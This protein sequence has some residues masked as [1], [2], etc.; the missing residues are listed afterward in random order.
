MKKAFCTLMALLLC[1]ILGGAAEETPA[2]YDSWD[3]EY[4]W[5]KDGSVAIAKYSGEADDLSIPAQVDGRPVTAIGEYAFLGCTSLTSVTIPD[6]VSTI[7]LA[8][9]GNCSNLTSVLI[10]SHDLDIGELAFKNC[11]SL[12]SIILPEGTKTIGKGAFSFCSSLTSVIIPD[13]VTTIGNSAFALCSKLNSISIPAS[14]SSVGDGIFVGCDG[15]TSLEI[16]DGIQVIPALMFNKCNGLI[17]ISIP[18]SVTSI[19]KSAF[20]ECANLTTVT[21]PD[22][23]TTIGDAVFYNCQSLTSITIPASVTSIGLNTFLS[24]DNL[25]LSVFKGSYA[26]QYCRDNGLPFEYSESVNQSNASQLEAEKEHTPSPTT[27][28][29]ESS[30]QDESFLMESVTQDPDHFKYCDYRRGAFAITEYN[31]SAT[32]LAIPASINGIPVVSIAS[33]AKYNETVTALYIPESVENIDGNPFVS[34][35]NLNSFYVAGENTNFEA[36]DGILYSKGQKEL[37]CYPSGRLDESF[38]IP[39]GTLRIGKDA[40]SYNHKISQLILPEGLLRIG[41]KAFF[42]MSSVHS[43]TIPSTVTE[44]GSNPFLQMLQLE[45][46]TVAPGN[47][48]FIIQ[49]GALYNKNTKLIICYPSQYASTSF[50]FPEDTITIGIGAFMR[51]TNL[52]DIVL[53]STVISIEV[54]AFYL[55]DNMTI[56]NLPSSIQHIGDLAFSGVCFNQ[57]TIPN[58]IQSVE[59]QCFKAAKCQNAIFESGIIV[60]PR[61]IFQDCTDLRTVQLPDTVESIESMS[62]SHCTSLEEIKL[63]ES[64]SFIDNTAF[65][66]CEALVACVVPGSYSEEYCKEQGIAYRY[67]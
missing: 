28:P 57:L 38:S 4:N 58:T 21:I 29:S 50:T 12:E 53:P 39:S 11:S 47:E 36:V 52:L 13:S 59:G 49:D 66:N 48:I 10:Q 45:E 56:S 27:L 24:C 37:L 35:V 67:S 3:F 18:E 22:S 17:S 64:I 19:G 1:L 15:L 25:K 61:R 33:I 43:I 31:G 7:N 51:N 54:G 63:P 62:F 65:E 60:I 9:F 20:I 46:I 40:F 8:A 34:F 55:C 42:A 16:V 23:V 6:S 32:N 26:V 5:L 14:V 2:A 30:T 44:M 41:D